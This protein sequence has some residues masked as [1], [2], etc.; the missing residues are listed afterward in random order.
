VSLDLEGR[1]TRIQPARLLALMRETPDAEKG[2]YRQLVERVV[3]R[4]A[5]EQDGK[6]AGMAQNRLRLLAYHEMMNFDAGGGLE[7]LANSPSE[8]VVELGELFQHTLRFDVAKELVRRYQLRW[9]RLLA[10]QSLTSFMAG[11][12]GRREGFKDDLKLDVQIVRKPA[13]TTTFVIFCGLAARFGQHLNIIHHCCMAKLDVNVVYLRDF[14]QLLYLT[15]IRSFGTLEQS[16]DRLRETIAGLGTTRVVCMGNS[17]GVFGALHYGSMLPADQVVVFSGPVSLQIG[18]EE[19]ERQA[20]QRLHALRLEGKV[21]WP[22]LRE[23]YAHNKIP[24]DFYFGN[25]NRVDT[26]QANTLA[27]LA[28]VRLR[29]LNSGSHVL[30]DEMH[31]SGHFDRV[32]ASAVA[33]K[34]FDLPFALQRLGKRFRDLAAPRT[35]SGK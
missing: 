18:F 25:Q 14:S 31:R 10:L 20:Y 17:G 26:A 8:A 27:D 19:A 24:V 15:G 3:F 6:R 35:A 32:L 33:T 29:P 16:C 2:G 30:I 22:D 34:R 1:I 12:E 21:E 9:P 28:N 23:I 7:G 13:A 5:D 4:H 11:L